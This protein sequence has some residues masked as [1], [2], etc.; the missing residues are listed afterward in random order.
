MLVATCVYAALWLA[1]Y[2]IGGRQVRKITLAELGVQPS[3]HRISFDS[4]GIYK[5]P[6]YGY[7]VVSY[8]PF[9]VTAR[10]MVWWQDEA[11]AGGT[12]VYFWF[13]VPSRPLKISD[14]RV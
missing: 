5:F 13:G 10:Y 8:A 2:L 6:A 11:A 1:T 7:S 3:Y 14:W 9:C 12:S 4:V